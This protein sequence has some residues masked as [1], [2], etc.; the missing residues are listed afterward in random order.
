MGKERITKK[1]DAIAEK[2]CIVVGNLPDF[3]GK[4]LLRTKL[5]VKIQ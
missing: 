5:S 2:H 1:L 4:G 3:C